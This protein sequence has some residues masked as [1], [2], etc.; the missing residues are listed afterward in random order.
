M[1]TVE[2]VQTEPKYNFV[3]EVAIDAV[4][5]TEIKVVNR[6]FG[7]KVFEKGGTIAFDV[8]HRTAGDAVSQTVAVGDT[9][10]KNLDVEHNYHAEDDPLAMRPGAL[11]GHFQAAS[12]TPTL[13]I[14]EVTD[15]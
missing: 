5:W 6:C 9:L 12:G 8:R 15:V 4:S 14:V 7:V 11:I 10:T 3:R 2:D 1:A 13:V